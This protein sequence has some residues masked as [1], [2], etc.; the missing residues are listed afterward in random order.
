[1]EHPPETLSRDLVLLRRYRR[2]DLDPLDRVITESLE[3]LLPW[4]PWA[5]GHCREAV[6][7]YL[8]RAER[9]WE[10]GAAYNY[11]ITTGGVLVGS[12][13]LMRR[14]GPGGLE[15]GYWL[16]P[17]WTGRGLVTMTA[18]AL[19]RAAFDLPGTTHVEVHHD[20]ANLASG[21]VPRRLG[22]TVVA[23]T[24]DPERSA[25]PAETGIDVVQR[26]DRAGA[27]AL[28]V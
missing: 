27:A 15:V 14:I 1:M 13:S 24:T 9:D 6:R 20:E 18:A 7:D 26:I 23:R 25:A 2:D 21:A 4:M 19:T 11:A 28:P 16:H 22:F 12:S 10:S 17:G 5:S 8:E 3:H